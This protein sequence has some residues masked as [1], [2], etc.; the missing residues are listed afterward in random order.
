MDEDGQAA[1]NE[2]VGV[3]TLAAVG[4]AVGASAAGKLAG[5]AAVGKAAG[6]GAA[7]GINAAAG[8]GAAGAAAVGGAAAG[9]ALGIAALI[10]TAMNLMRKATRKCGVI[11]GGKAR[12]VCIA[13]ARLMGYQKIGKAYQKQV[14]KCT[15]DK[16][17]SVW[18]KKLS[19][20][21]GKIKHQQEV[22]RKKSEKAG[23][24]KTAKGLK[25]ATDKKKFRL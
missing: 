10:R 25:M 15:T 12:K 16:C 6:T 9:A 2:I 21:S 7:M 18:K 5:A 1:L 13:K 4:K 24:E 14:S 17:K 22:L 11:R 3:G 23:T 8:G 19:N 20:L